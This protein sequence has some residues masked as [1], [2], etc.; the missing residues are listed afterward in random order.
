MATVTV[1]KQILPTETPESVGL[2]PDRLARLTPLIEGHI[3]AGKYPGAQLAV[4]RYGKLVRFDTFGSAKIAPEPVCASP[5][6][7]WLIFSQ[8]KVIVAAAIWQL[9][10]AGE[11]R[12][13]DRIAD[14]VPEFAANG[15]ADVSV[16]QIITH[17]GGFPTARVPAEAWSDHDLLRRTVCEFSLEWTPGSKVQ[18]HDLAAHWV[19]GVLIE[20]ITGTDFRDHVKGNLIVPLGLEDDIFIGVS[21]EDDGRCS[22][23]HQVV[24][25][26]MTHMSID[27]RAWRAA[28]IPGGGGY[29]TARGLTAFY[30]ML[31][32]GGVL[33][34]K[35]VLGPRVIEFAT[36]NHTGNRI[37]QRMGMAMHRGL[38]PHVR[39]TSPA[40]RGLGAIASPS[41]YGHGGVGSSYSWGDPE[42][43]VAFTYLSNCMVDD[44]WHS[45]R[46]DALSNIVH[47][48]I[49]EL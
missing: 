32:A 41:T 4:S 35:R 20:A 21:D 26:V 44:P 33:D 13:S 47:A 46:L 37:D 18:Y 27:N 3:A 11:L 17:Q 30:Q 19:L 36:R 40:I 6:T 43:G 10:E 8:T 42:S 38:G 39:G 34:G 7:L 24:D 48:S 12:F 49:V 1:R 23:M 16:F 29:A 31:L 25:G 22:D 15:K 5:D 45:A 2:D 28:G 9:V 14:H